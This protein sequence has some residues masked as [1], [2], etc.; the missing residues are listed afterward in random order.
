[1]SNGCFHQR[2]KVAA[3]IDKATE[4]LRRWWSQ[5]RKIIKAMVAASGGKLVIQEAD[6]ERECTHESVHTPGDGT[7]TW[8]VTLK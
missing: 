4:D 6:L 3:M 5:D 8:R 2:A 1:M 7:Q